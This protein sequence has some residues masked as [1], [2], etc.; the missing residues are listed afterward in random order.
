MS[1]NRNAA[2]TSLFH[3]ASV[4]QTVAQQTS[5]SANAGSDNVQQYLRRVQDRIQELVSWAS[6]IDAPNRGPYI[7]DDDDEELIDPR[8]VR[9][10]NATQTNVRDS[11]PE[12][13]I[14]VTYASTNTSSHA[15]PTVP[16]LNATKPSN[17][18]KRATGEPIHLPNYPPRRLLR[19]V[20]SPH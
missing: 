7:S 6:D 16:P 2:T 8:K 3:A 10:S 14:N 9:R 13:H 12:A 1:L 18:T 4:L 20:L 15:K 19:T 11:E 17:T 5:H